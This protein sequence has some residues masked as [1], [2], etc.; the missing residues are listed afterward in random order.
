MLSRG[1][2]SMNYANTLMGSSFSIQTVQIWIAVC[3]L[4]SHG[5]ACVAKITYKK[6]LK[7]GLLDM[8]NYLALVVV[9]L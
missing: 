9:L 1:K 4:S 3:Q 5:L 2:Y 7:S 8:K 6:K